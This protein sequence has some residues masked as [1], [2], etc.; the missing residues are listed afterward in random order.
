[1]TAANKR[2][3]E[4]A[5]AAI[6]AGDH[7]GFL[8]CCTD[9]TQWT[10]VGDTTIRGKAALREWMAEAYREP[11]RFDVHRMMAEGDFVTALGEITLKDED[12]TPTR[13]AY[14]DVWRF[15]GGRMA[16]LQAFV[17]EATTDGRVEPGA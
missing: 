14:C 9:D 5:N 3:L 13:Y 8:T 1:V 17:I 6:A 2:T 12:G 7:E 11:P 15:S 4:R 10:F 16:E